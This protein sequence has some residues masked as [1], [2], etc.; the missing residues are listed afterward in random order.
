MFKSDY[1]KWFESQPKW[2]QKW[3]KKQAIWYTRDLFM[4]MFYGF[5]IGFMIR[6]I[7]VG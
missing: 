6:I 5:V 3:M 7:V 4:F 2:T 1:R